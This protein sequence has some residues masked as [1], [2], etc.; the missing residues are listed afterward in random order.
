VTNDSMFT[1]LYFFLFFSS[2]VLYS[3]R[4][5]QGEVFYT[6]FFILGIHRFQFQSVPRI[7]IDW[8]W[9]RIWVETDYL[10]SMKNSWRSDQNFNS[11]LIL[12]HFQ[13]KFRLV[14]VPILDEHLI[15]RYSIILYRFIFKQKNS[16]CCTK[17]I[18]LYD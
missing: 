5:F 9:L 7:V 16:I 3:N 1:K 18:K 6:N 11:K 13:L 8:N 4:L 2:I 14:P 12:G 10:K 17:L 15:A